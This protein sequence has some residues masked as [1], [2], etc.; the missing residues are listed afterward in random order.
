MTDAAMQLNSS[1]LSRR[2]FLRASAG[3]AV[4]AP[5]AA[6]AAQIATRSAFAAPALQSA[7]SV[8]WQLGWTKS[9]QFGGFFAAIDK[10]FYAEQGINPDVRAGGPQI[11]P[12]SLVA[13]GASMIGDAGSF[14]VI[15]ARA[16]GVPIKSFMAVFQ[17]SPFCV[18]SLPENPIT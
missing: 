6:T 3:L 1:T 10:G 9:V 7:S 8:S 16:A 2:R 5:L 12:I 18:M 11:N 15:R 4:A 13:G 17:K 14:D